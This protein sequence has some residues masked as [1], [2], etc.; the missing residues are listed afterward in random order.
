M[1]EEKNLKPALFDQNQ[2]QSKT[3]LTREL[4]RVKHVGSSKKILASL[5]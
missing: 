2:L 3:Q 1:P 4:Q 5:L